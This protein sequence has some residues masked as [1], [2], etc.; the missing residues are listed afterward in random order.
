MKAERERERLTLW[1]NFEEVN[2]REWEGEDLFRE[3][4]VKPEQITI[5][6]P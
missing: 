4:D 6:C 5:S 2:E 1:K 3:S